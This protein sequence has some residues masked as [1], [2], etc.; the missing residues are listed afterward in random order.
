MR[1]RSLSAN[2]QTV[3]GAARKISVDD[4]GRGVKAAREV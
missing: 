3:D 4:Q 2:A 1:R